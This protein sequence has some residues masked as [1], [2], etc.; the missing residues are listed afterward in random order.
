MVKVSSQ[1]HSS[2]NG[3]ASHVLRLQR[4]TPLYLFFKAYTSQEDLPLSP[5]KKLFCWHTLAP[6][7]VAWPT[8]K[9]VSSCATA[10]GSTSN[11]WGLTVNIT[12][13]EWLESHGSETG[14]RSICSPVHTP[15]SK[16]PSRLSRL[17]HHHHDLLESL[18]HLAK[19][20]L[21]HSNNSLSLQTQFYNRW[22]LTTEV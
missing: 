19:Q 2:K 12:L 17:D 5:L 22:V 9:K 13:H 8:A 1:G 11:D 7:K 14:V 4:C 18:N 16:Q 20:R 6:P 15:S 3:K 10:P 21:C